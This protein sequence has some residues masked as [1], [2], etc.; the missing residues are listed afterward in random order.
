MN[1]TEKPSPPQML[2]SEICGLLSYISLF[3]TPPGFML[4]S[5]RLNF[6]GPIWSEERRV[7]DMEREGNQ[8]EI[9]AKYHMQCLIEARFIAG[10]MPSQWWVLAVADLRT[11]HSQY[12]TGPRV[13]PTSSTLLPLLQRRLK[14]GTARW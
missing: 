14:V 11:H 6:N 2:S 3:L 1:L 5:Q 8:C 12:S 13:F 9:I 4:T 10:L 7:M